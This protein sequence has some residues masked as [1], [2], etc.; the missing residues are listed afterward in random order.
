MIVVLYQRKLRDHLL[1]KIDKNWKKCKQW[2]A[3]GAREARPF[4]DEAI[5]CTFSVFF[6]IFPKNDPGS[7]PH[8]TGLATSGLTFSRRR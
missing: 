3:K 7:F 5:F 2:P 1:G 4:V 8:W 6:A